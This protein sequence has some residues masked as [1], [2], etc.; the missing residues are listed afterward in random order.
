MS[1]TCLTTEVLAAR[2]HFDARA[3]HNKLVDLCLIGGRHY[4]RSFGR[5]K[6]LSIWK[7]FT[8]LT[9]EM[10]TTCWSSFSFFIVWHGVRD[11]LKDVFNS[12]PKIGT[13]PIHCIQLNSH[14]RFFIQ[15]SDS[16]SMQAC[17]AG[18]ISNSNFLFSH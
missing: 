14:S 1:A 17:C 18:H 4:V 12:T 8:K 2:V 11:V 10:N 13:Q 7:R 5:R 6:M 3:I 15:Q 9:L 16:P